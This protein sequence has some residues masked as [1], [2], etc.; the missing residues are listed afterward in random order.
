MG[1]LNP[2]VI[3]LAGRSDVALAKKLFKLPH[4]L[5]ASERVKCCHGQL[6]K[7]VFIAGPK[8]DDGKG[9]STF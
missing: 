9:A 4:T 5:K 7:I 3:H 1:G 6:D 8:K 2:A